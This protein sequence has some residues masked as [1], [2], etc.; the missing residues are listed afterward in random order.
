MACCSAYCKTSTKWFFVMFVLCKKLTFFR[1]FCICCFLY[2]WCF[3]KQNTISVVVFV[4]PDCACF[5]CFFFLH[6]LFQISNKKFFVQSFPIRLPIC[7]IL[8]PRNFS[9]QTPSTFWLIVITSTAKQKKSP[10]QRF[11]QTTAYKFYHINTSFF[12]FFSP[13]VD[14]IQI[15]VCF[16]DT[17]P[18]FRKNSCQHRR[19]RDRFLFCFDL[20]SAC[21]LLPLFENNH[22]INM[23][24]ACLMPWVKKKH[25]Q[26]KRAFASVACTREVPV[27]QLIW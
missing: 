8:K 24:S 4:T 6:L 18:I 1:L 22:Q 10:G 26:N 12:L 17:C 27:D 19:Q 9:V 20:E 15:C 11:S 14:S 13:S 21:V 16:R 3:S 23:S 2:V 7:F 25:T 5:T